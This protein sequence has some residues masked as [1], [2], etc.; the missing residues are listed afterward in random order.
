MF[1]IRPVKETDLEAIIALTQQTGL[2]FTTLPKNKQ[3]MQ[4]LVT[5][6]AASFHQKTGHAFYFFV[7]EEIA[8]HELVGTAGILSKTAHKHYFELTRQSLPP[9]FPE[10]PSHLSLLTQTEKFD[11]SS[12]LCSLF[13]LPKARKEGLGKLLSL[14]RFHFIAANREAFSRLIFANLRGVTKEGGYCPFWEAVGRHFFHVDFKTLMERRETDDAAVLDIM[15]KYPLYLDLLSEE[16]REVLGAPHS[17]GVPA[18]KM[19]LG[20]GFKKTEAFDLYDGGPRLEANIDE[21]K[22]ITESQVVPVYAIQEDLDAPKVLVSNEKG[23]FRA[24]LG[25]FDPESKVIDR[26]AADCLEIDVNDPIRY[27]YARI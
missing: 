6:G 7:L 16:A 23:P 22:T 5:Q 15:P 9:L 19:L 12:E 2:G 10:I 13:L 25:K 4:L 3:R 24:C 27:S 17:E 26:K 11:E 21:I 18:F 8:S 14:S 20:Q 1:R